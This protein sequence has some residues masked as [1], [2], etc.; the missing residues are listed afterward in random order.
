MS[1]MDDMDFTKPQGALRPASPAPTPTA[2]PVAAPFKAATSRFYNA[3]VAAQVFK[4]SGREER[5]APEQELFAEDEAS[6]SGG[7]LGMRSGSRMYFIAEGDVAL[8][9]AGKPLDIV[10]KGDVFGEMSVISGRPRSATATAK[11]AGL[12]YS[13]DA[14]ELQTALGRSPEFAMMLASVMYDRLRLI[15]A[16]LASRALKPGSAARE[17]SV[18]DPQLLG[19]LEQAL[20][21]GA[22]LRY[23]QGT[24]IMK[25]GQVGVY[26]YVVKTG[27]VAIAIGSNIVEAVGPGGAFGEMAVIDQSP[28]TARA[29][30]VEDTE[31]LAID[32]PTLLAAVKKEPAFAMAMLR[33]IADRLRHMNSLLS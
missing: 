10:T 23:P 17:A 7:M 24:I 27:R 22:L 3:E 8:T 12:V 4:A 33:G 14:T 1:D 26:M 32:R 11:A 20:P 29:G 25:E 30:A 2:P 16:R 28:R 19:R 31:L 9:R 18:F 6:K 13:L 15:A 21:R 5:I